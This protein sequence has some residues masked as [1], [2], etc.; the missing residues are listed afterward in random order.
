VTSESKINK[1]KK[2]YLTELK[3]IYEK[4]VFNNK[5]Y[6]EIINVKKFLELIIEENELNIES[7]NVEILVAGDGCKCKKFSKFENNL[8][9]FYLKILNVQNNNLSKMVAPIVCFEGSETFENLKN[10]LSS[11][12][13]KLEDLENEKILIK[14]VEKKIKIFYGGDYHFISTNFNVSVKNK[15][16]CV[17]CK[18][19]DIN[20]YNENFEQRNLIGIIKKVFVHDTLHM[21]LATIK[22]FFQN[23]QE[24]LISEKGDFEKIQK[25]LFDNNLN[26]KFTVTSKFSFIGKHFTI[27]MDNNFL[28]LKKIIENIYT[29]EEIEIIVSFFKFIDDISTNKQSNN[30]D[31]ISFLKNKKYEIILDNYKKKIMVHKNFY[32]IHFIF[33]MVETYI[34]YGSCYFFS[35]QMMESMN[36]VLK[37]LI[38]HHTNH[39]RSDFDY[40]AQMLIFYCASCFH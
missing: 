4:K 23:M 10:Y 3:S 25:I 32:Y 1:I 5:F 15:Q 14:G 6:Y 35:T 39:S 20:K 17:H 29:N 28:I 16:F 13:K 37:Q 12:S 24:K 18:I 30:N 7:E 11:I 27:L 9:F 40:M 26:F 19:D 2:N 22:N 34:N 33:H 36:R 21:R 31:F 8:N 38:R